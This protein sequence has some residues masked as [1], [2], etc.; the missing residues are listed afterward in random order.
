MNLNIDI[1]SDLII[2]LDILEN[3]QLFNI[4]SDLQLKL[5]E[6]INWYSH[7]ELTIFG[8][9]KEKIEM[10]PNLKNINVEYGNRVT[11]GEEESYKRINDKLHVNFQ[12]YR[13]GQTLYVVI[14]TSEAI[15]L[16]KVAIKGAITFTK[17]ADSFWGGSCSSDYD[18]G[19]VVDPTW[20]EVAFMAND[21]I[22]E[23]NDM[24]HIF[25]EGIGNGTFFMG[26]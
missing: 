4:N 25:L 22:I 8:K 19:K 9:G 5:L 14:S 1:W 12:K 3:Q 7:K 26:S 24:H 21:M 6:N 2:N 16:D 23:T 18:S 15:S 10:A 17:K 13:P 20:L 11:D